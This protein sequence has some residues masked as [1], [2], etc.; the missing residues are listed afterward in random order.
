MVE[1]K[2][3]CR[4]V[5]VELGKNVSLNAVIEGIDEKHVISWLH[6][7]REI[8]RGEEF[9]GEDGLSEHIFL[10]GGTNGVFTLEITNAQFL[11]KGT[12]SIKVYEQGHDNSLFEITQKDVMLLEV[13]SYSDDMDMRLEGALVSDSEEYG[14]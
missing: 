4:Y 3:N 14:V 7:G 12:Y 13:D 10:R 11:D 5:C 6:N 9:I 8:T 1:I 2:S